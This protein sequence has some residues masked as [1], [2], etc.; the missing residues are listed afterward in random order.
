[1]VGNP[2]EGRGGRGLD[3]EDPGEGPGDRL[4]HLRL[5]LRRRRARGALRRQIQ[6]ARAL[7][8]HGVPQQGP[9]RLAFWPLAEAATRGGL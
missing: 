8:A 1:M 9:R 2:A 7:G 5:R 4:R 3:P 6:L